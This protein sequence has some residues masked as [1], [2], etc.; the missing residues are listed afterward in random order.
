MNKSSFSI[1][2]FEL[3]FKKKS[4]PKMGIIGCRRG[5]LKWNHL[6]NFHIVSTDQW[7]LIHVLSDHAEFGN[8]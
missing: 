5:V 4:H 2:K 1:T 6:R 3:F 7:F 8:S